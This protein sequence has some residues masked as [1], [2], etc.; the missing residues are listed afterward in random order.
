MLLVTAAFLAFERG[1]RRPT[2]LV[3]IALALSAS[4]GLLF[5]AALGTLELFDRPKERQRRA[6]ILRAF[7]YTGICGLFVL[8]LRHSLTG[9]AL[10]PFEKLL[11]D[12]DADQAEVGAHYLWSFAYASG[13]A[14]VLPRPSWHWPAGTSHHELD[15]QPCSFWSGAWVAS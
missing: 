6:S 11:L 10:S 15:V 5:V 1:W 2:V 9:S 4:E 14:L 12:L 3:L 7:L 8:V 13:L